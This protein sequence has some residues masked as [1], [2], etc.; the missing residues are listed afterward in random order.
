MKAEKIKRQC[1]DAVLEIF[2]FRLTHS[3]AVHITINSESLTTSLHAPINFILFLCI[4]RKYGNFI[5]VCV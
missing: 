5:D 2:F 3:L 1:F 4:S